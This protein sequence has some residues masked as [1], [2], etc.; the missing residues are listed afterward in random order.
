MDLYIVSTPEVRTW[1]AAA[2]ASYLAKPYGERDA[3]LDAFCSQDLAGAAGSL[4]KLDLGVKAAAY[5]KERGHFRA[6]W[7]MPRSSISKTPLRMAN[8][9]GLIDA[10]YR[11]TLLGATDFQQEYKVVAGDRYYQIVAA[12]LLPWAH[13]H[14]VDEIPGGPTLRGAGGFGSTGLRTN[15]SVSTCEP[16]I[17]PQFQT[18]RIDQ[19]E[20]VWQSCTGF[21]KSDQRSDQTESYTEFQQIPPIPATAGPQEIRFDAAT[22]TVTAH[23]L[24]AGSYFGQ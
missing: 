22:S 13:I 9:M 4:Q 24:A 1:Y 14:I 15:K 18:F 16:T 17:L 8:S 10:G 23:M 3:G 20:S 21:G 19:S 7:L 11:G 2:I 6:F 12:D 5:D